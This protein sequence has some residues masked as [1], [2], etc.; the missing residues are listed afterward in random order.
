MSIG[1]DLGTTNS[2]VCVF[3][4]G[5]PEILANAQGNRT[6]PSIV[7]FNDDQRL[8]GDG[9]KNQQSRNPLHTI[10]CAKRLIGLKWDDEGVSQD[11]ATFPFKCLKGDNNDI[12]INV[13]YKGKNEN[14]T[15]TQ[16]S[17]MV[18]THMKET[19]ELSLGIPVTEAVITVPARF[20]NQQ[21]Q[22]TMDAAAIAG[23][24]CLRIIN[25]P[26]AASLAYSIGK[27][28]DN[29]KTILVFDYGGG[30]MDVTLLTL[31]P[32]GIVEVLSTEGDVHMGGEDLDLI[33]LDHFSKEFKKKHHQNLEGAR[34]KNRLQKACEQAKR[35]LSTA[36]QTMVQVD[37]LQDGID[38][39]CNFTRAR[40][41]SLCGSNFRN[42]MKYV[43]MALKNA[44]KGKN[45]IDEV[46]LVGGSTRIPM[47]QKL[48]SDYFN[49][50]Q[51][52]K[53]VNPDEAVAIG[54][55]VQADILNGG[56]TEETKEMLLLD[57][58]PLSL[59]LETMGCQMEI[60]IP[61]NSTIPT[62]KTKSFTTTSNNQSTVEL[63]V[64]EGERPQTINNN[65][66]GSFMLNGIPP[67]PARTPNIEVTFNLNANGVLEVTAK[68]TKNGKE[69]SIKI[70]SKNQLSKEE[71]D[72]M[73]SDAEKYKDDDNK[74]KQKMDA[75]S[76]YDGF[77]YA[78]VKQVEDM[79]MTDDEQSECKKTL[80][81]AQ[82]WVSSNPLATAEDVTQQHKNFDNKFKEL[83]Q[84]IA[85]RNKTSDETSDETPNKTSDETPNK[86]SDE[87]PDE[88]PNDD[89]SNE[90]KVEEL[91]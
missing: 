52:C 70:E 28:R 47:V 64:Y 88:T 65:L 8:I 67:S 69:E 74:F 33:L 27:K 59:G 49:G 7:S 55:A 4:N 23:L 68:D 50:K 15:P 83:L 76:Q 48:L 81:D 84:P 43:D 91:D 16:I 54:A 24:K 6:T 72:K 66:L 31:T 36:T 57:V 37:S 45:E 42:T 46:V 58:N 71:V 86:T 12:L 34:S 26:T 82:S 56:S 41:E 5:A 13:N 30:T 9:A 44:G 25:E 29:D 40:F 21:R 61:K 90:P 35:V 19:A 77:V 89:T 62:S 32:D 80:D 63:K 2:C 78:M 39:S 11:V 60:L 85:I 53:S 79:K 38:F 3:R 17:A 14:F 75:I 87:T 22:A 10:Y 20:N 1:I 73:V 18:L 51:L